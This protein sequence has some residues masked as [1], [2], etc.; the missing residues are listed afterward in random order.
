MNRRISHLLSSRPW[1]WIFAC[2]LFTTFFLYRCFGLSIQEDLLD[3]WPEDDPGLTFLKEK[4]LVPF[5]K[6]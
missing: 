2:M 1:L 5:N 3:Y 4:D 6:R